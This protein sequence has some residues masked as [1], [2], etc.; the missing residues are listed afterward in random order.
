MHK[1]YAPLEYWKLTPGQKKDICNGCGAKD[2][3]SVPNTIYFLCVR[4]AC[5]IHDYM[6]HVGVTKADKLFA[7]AM[8]RQNL[9]ILISK[10]SNWFT[11]ILRQGRA[12]KYYIAVSQWG[13]SAYWENKQYNNNLEITYKG[14]FA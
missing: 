14:F 10:N 3:I 13:E 5:Q 4:E 8:F 11:S 2:G 12:S 1:L 9:T 7:D 6:Y